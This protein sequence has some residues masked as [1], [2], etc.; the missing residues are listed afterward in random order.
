MDPRTPKLSTSV[1]D[2]APSVGV[3]FPRFT[4]EMREFVDET[5]SVLGVGFQI[6][7]MVVN[8]EN[9][10]VKK[11]MGNVFVLGFAEGTNG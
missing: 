11:K 2:A 1:C 6:V 7:I 4:K 10:A 8:V 5:V 3:C 9:V